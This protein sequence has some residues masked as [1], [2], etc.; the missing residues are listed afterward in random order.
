MQDRGESARQYSGHSQALV[1]VCRG[2][3]LGHHLVIRRVRLTWCAHPWGSLAPPWAR[4]PLPP[5]MSNY[6]HWIPRARPGA[7]GWAT[8]PADSGIVCPASLQRCGGECFW[9]CCAK[10]LPCLSALCFPNKSEEGRTCEVCVV[11][12]NCILSN[13]GSQEE[14]ET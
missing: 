6:A 3:G 11:H 13:P 5:W 8:G 10:H 1:T 7:D 2:A 4:G 14:T 9:W 12:L